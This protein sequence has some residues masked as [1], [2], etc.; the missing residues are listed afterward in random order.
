MHH[1][2]C[3]EARTASVLKHHMVAET[4]GELTRVK[5]LLIPTVLQGR[6]MS[7]AALSAQTRFCQEVSAAGGDYLLFVKQTQPTF[8]EEGSLFFREPPL[9]CLDW[10]T[11]STTHKGHGR[12]ENRLITVSTELHAFLARDCHDVGQVFCLRRRV[13]HALKCTRASRV[14]DHQSHAPSVL[15]PPVCWN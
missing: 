6:I 15:I 3:Y 14:W 4:E 7:A 8:D 12:V 1:V 5:E 10:R 2:N 11:A 13:H 9:D